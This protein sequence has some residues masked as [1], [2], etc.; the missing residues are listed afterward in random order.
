MSRV[1]SCAPR[2]VL[3]I[4]LLALKKELKSERALKE[5]DLPLRIVTPRY[6]HSETNSNANSFS[7]RSKTASLPYS[8]EREGANKAKSSS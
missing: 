3:V 5:N 1:C 6:L 2:S 8:A 4:A 7:A